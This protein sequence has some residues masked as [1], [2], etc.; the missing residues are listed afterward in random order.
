MA[1]RFGIP[2]CPEDD[3]RPMH[4]RLIWQELCKKARSLGMRIYVKPIAYKLTDWSN[5]KRGYDVNLIVNEQI[6]NHYKSMLLAKQICL[7]AITGMLKTDK[8]S[9]DEIELIREKAD[10][11]GQKLYKA[12]HTRVYPPPKRPEGY[13]SINTAEGW[14][15]LAEKRQGKIE[16]AHQ[17]ILHLMQHIEDATSE[18]LEIMQSYLEAAAGKVG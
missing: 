15:A 1:H 7:W 4:N 6:P 5:G 11:A 16:E 18:E 8:L 2:C 17:R 3:Q 13:K 9:E 12:I 10:K 14:N